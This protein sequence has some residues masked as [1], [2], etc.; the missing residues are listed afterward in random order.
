MILSNKWSDFEL[1]DCGD[2]QKIERW[3]KFLLK[4]PDPQAIWPLA[5]DD[6]VD[7]VYHRN[8]KGGGAWQ[9]QRRCPE[10]WLIHYPG[11]HKPYTFQVHP[12]SFKHTG[13]FPEQAANW[14][15]I[16]QVI[17]RAKAAGQEVRVLNLFAYTGGATV[18]A[19]LAGADEV[20]HVDASKGMIQEAKHNLQKS[21]GQ[22]AF[23]RFICDDVLK[24]VARENRRGRQ[25]H[26]II[27]DPPAYG[28]GPSGELWQLEDQLC[29]LLQLTESLLA[30]EALLFILNAYATTI[31]LG[32][33]TQTVKLV[34]QNPRG[35]RVWGD[36][37]GLLSSQRSIILPCGMT[38]HW[39]APACTHL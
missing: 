20:V 4:R 13:L 22:D 33:L 27:M 18:A 31:S 15:K 8:A 36:E 21:G 5:Y 12:T 3:G 9:F 25:Y 35:G 26:V 28:R 14:D 32:A 29:S 11:L 6:P 16:A 1:I 10:R 39:E 38:I 24:F 7:A 23:V 37:L 19:A 2:G 17:Q 30:Q 34:L